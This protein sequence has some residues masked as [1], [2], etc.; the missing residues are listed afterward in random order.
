LFGLLSALFGGISMH[1]AQEG[2]WMT[3][4][5]VGQRFGITAAAARM[6]ANPRG[7]ERRTP[8][9]CGDRA[10]VLVPVEVNVQ[11]RPALF[12]ER[13]GNEIAR[14]QGTPSEDDQPNDTL[15]VQVIELAIEALTARAADDRARADRAEEEVASLRA[16]VVETR[17]AE[18][19]ADMA[20]KAA[21]AEVSDLRKQLEATEQRAVEERGRADRERDRADQAE[22]QLASKEA[23]V[24]GLVA[25]SQELRRRVSELNELV[26]TRQRR[27]WWQRLFGG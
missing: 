24:I 5:E 21:T 7:W 25:Q 27:S 23:T 13:A 26:R 12:P 17:M 16:E 3:Y 19:E 8:N 10:R 20:A 18:V 11:P 9:A 2:E 22:R 15:N 14:N 6:Y 1:E 4:V